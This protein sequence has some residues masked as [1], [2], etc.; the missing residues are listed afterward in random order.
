MYDFVIIGGGI[1]GMSTAMQLIEIYRR[2][3][4]AAGK[5]G[6]PGLPSDWPQQRRDPRRGV[7]HARQPQAVLPAG[8]RATKA[9]ASRTASAMTSAAN[10]GR[11]RRW[12]WSG[13]APCGIA[14]PP[15]ACS[16]SG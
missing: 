8:N 16:A 4:C 14:P 9:F 7:L 13:C 10:A 1:I 5:R 11:H 15:T 2:P 6:R 3:H 12:R